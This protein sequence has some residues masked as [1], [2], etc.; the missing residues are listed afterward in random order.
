MKAK[1]D[2]MTSESCPVA[3]SLIQVLVPSNALENHSDDHHKIAVLGRQSI[4]DQ[5]LIGA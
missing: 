5:L 1:V 3:D 4:N 2:L